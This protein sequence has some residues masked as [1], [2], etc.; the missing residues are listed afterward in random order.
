M[1]ADFHIHTH[2]LKCAN[3][4]MTVPAIVQKCTE[5]GL[6]MIGIADHL[7]V[8]E[9]LPLFRKIKEDI[10]ALRT[11]LPVFF[12]CELNYSGR[13][14]PYDAEIEKQYGFQYAIGG[15]HGA[16]TKEPSLRTIIDIQHKLLCECAA[17]PLFDVV[18]H[19]WWYG[20]SEFTRNNLPWLED[21]SQIPKAYTRE[22]AQIAR[23]NGKAIEINGMA[24]FWN[25][26]YSD[27]FR[28]EYVEHLA[29]MN[30]EGVMF[31]LA[32]DAHA[33]DQLASVAEPIRVAEELKIPEARLW[34]PRAER[35]A[36]G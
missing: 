20:R 7:N 28:K 11:S 32:S 36:S 6:E 31:A 33:I 24:I 2:Y 13:P 22:F 9:N 29:V 30:E 34:R 15:L 17:C 25:T 19:P 10:A 18:V 14:M 21:M 1:K 8:R 3:Q 35:A 4:T 12:G 5:L 27:R 16:H 26:G 23:Q